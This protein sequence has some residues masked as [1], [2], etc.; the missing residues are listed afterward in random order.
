M[1]LRNLL[2]TAALFVTASAAFAGKNKDTVLPSYQDFS[3]ITKAD[4]TKTLNIKMYVFNNGKWD[5]YLYGNPVQDQNSTQTEL[6]QLHLDETNARS[7]GEVIATKHN[8]IVHEPSLVGDVPE[9]YRSNLEQKTHTIYTFSIPFNDA[10]ISSFG[11]SGANSL[12]NTA[13]GELSS[14]L[15]V[16]YNSLPANNGMTI[17]QIASSTDQT[18]L[19]H[20]KPQWHLNNGALFLISV[21]SPEIKNVG[22]PL[23]APVVTLLIALGFGAALVMYRNHKQVKA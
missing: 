17:D 1:K 23:P 20:A 5:Y 6:Y 8:Q 14:D 22:S 4:E 19:V 13:F 18:I 9:E 3:T 21:D 11:I 15:T 7:Y 2:L 10:D 16:L 12:N